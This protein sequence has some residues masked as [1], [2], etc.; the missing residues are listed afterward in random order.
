MATKAISRPISRRPTLRTCATW[1][2]SPTASALLAAAAVAA[3]AGGIGVYTYDG[4][5]YEKRT[6]PPAPVTDAML[7]TAPKACLDAIKRVG[8]DPSC[9]VITAHFPRD[10][11]VEEPPLVYDDE[12]E[13]IPPTLKQLRAIYFEP[14]EVWACNGAV[15][16]VGI[17]DCLN[18]LEPIEAAQ[19]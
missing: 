4:A 6:T 16:P 18:A 14:R 11:N 15:M 12:G 3:A 5:T 17:Q 7:L 1:Q 8:P 10:G 9:S 19:E 2:T 13:E